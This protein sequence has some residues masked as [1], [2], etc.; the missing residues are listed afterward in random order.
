MPDSGAAAVMVQIKPYLVIIVILLC[1]MEYH[2]SDGLLLL[3]EGEDLPLRAESYI[4][5]KI[6]I[7]LYQ[8]TISVIVPIGLPILYHG[9]LVLCYY[10]VW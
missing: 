7:M 2:Q 3:P 5:G 6:G 10:M 8:I 9:I 1:F 4:Q